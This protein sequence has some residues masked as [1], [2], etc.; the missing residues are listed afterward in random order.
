VTQALAPTLA[1]E[2]Q[3]QIGD[4]PDGDGQ[5]EVDEPVAEDTE[6]RRFLG[7]AEAGQGGDEDTFDHTEA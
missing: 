3:R 6:D 7:D 5:P 1:G 2:S 4:A